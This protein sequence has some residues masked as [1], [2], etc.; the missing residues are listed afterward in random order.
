MG[1]HSSPPPPEAAASGVRTDRAT[2]PAALGQSAVAGLAAVVIT[3]VGLL[4]AGV[5]PRIAAA[6]GAGLLAVGVIVFLLAQ[7]SGLVSERPDAPAPAD[8][9][10]HD[11]GHP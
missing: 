1:K 6:S 10:S 2:G 9:R 11:G 8:P 5:D 7:R 4:W 3:V